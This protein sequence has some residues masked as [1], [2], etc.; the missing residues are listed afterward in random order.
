M[1]YLPTSEDNPL[2]T[3]RYGHRAYCESLLRDWELT[4]H[5]QDIIEP[6]DDR[7]IPFSLAPPDKGE[8]RVCFLP[9]FEVFSNGSAVA[10]HTG[11]GFVIRKDGA[12]VHERSYPLSSS[13]DL[14]AELYAIWKAGEWF[15]LLWAD[16]YSD[17]NHIWV[18]QHLCWVI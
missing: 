13:S 18:K 8:R 16:S 1:R 14:Q 2:K 11:C 3:I 4:L 5:S 12:Q 6:Y 9:Q 15:L 17:V 10:G 7:D